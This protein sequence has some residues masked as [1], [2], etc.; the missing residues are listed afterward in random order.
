MAACMR[1]GSAHASAGFSYL[2]LLFFVAITG[3]A[4]AAL[5]QG[6]STAAQ[7]E[8]EREL[9]FRGLEI[10]RAIDSYLAAGGVAR[11]HPRTLD[12]LMRDERG[13][14]GPRH[15][16]RRRYADPFTGQ[17]DWVLLPAPGDP[18][19][20]AGVRSRSE[21]PLLRQLDPEAEEATR[22]SQW[23]FQAGQ[24]EI[25]LA[26]PPGG[27]ASGVDGRAPAQD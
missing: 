5:G 4:L 24:A 1:T 16:L 11:V 17:A 8:R 12:D 6:W 23:L 21:R 15:H 13:P 19:G 7:R 25:G 3:A 9:E 2:G 26:P 18:A 22:A 27:A 14:A 20:F 10:A